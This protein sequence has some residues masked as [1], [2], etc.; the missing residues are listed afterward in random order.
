MRHMIISLE[1]RSG[2]RRVVCVSAR[3]RHLLLFSQCLLSQGVE[4]GVLFADEGL[5]VVALHVVPGDAVARVEAV[6]HRQA[7]L[8]AGAV[9][10]LRLA[11]AARLAP[12][13]ALHALAVTPGEAVAS[14]AA[15]ARPDVLD[16]CADRNRAVRSPHL[17]R[18][19][20][21]RRRSATAQ[22]QDSHPKIRLSYSY[23]SV[24]MLIQLACFIKDLF[25]VIKI[26]TQLL[27]SS[28]IRSH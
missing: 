6:Q 7:V 14:A 1:A 5:L 17:H 23:L 27:K 2:R 15:T 26:V 18:H 25:T 3:P 19:L 9:V 13:V 11:V 22:R 8:A 21:E 20:R 16:P 10:R 12:A 4:G 28:L 24:D